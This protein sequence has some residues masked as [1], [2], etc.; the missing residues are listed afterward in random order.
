MKKNETLTSAISL[1]WQ[2][3]DFRSVRNAGSG[4]SKT[5]IYTTD[6]S[7]T[8]E[9]L[10]LEMEKDV[11]TSDI[12]PKLNALSQS[13]EFFREMPTM[14]QYSNNYKNRLHEYFEFTN[15]LGSQEDFLRQD[16]N[17]IVNSGHILSIEISTIKHHYS[18]YGD[19]LSHQ[20]IGD[21][22]RE[23]EKIKEHINFLLFKIT[24]SQYPESDDDDI[25]TVT[26]ASQLRYLHCLGFFEF[27]NAKHPNGK[28]AP[29]I[30]RIINTVKTIDPQLSVIRSNK[31]SDSNHPEASENEL[32]KAI[33]FLKKNNF[34]VD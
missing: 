3:Y 34:N 4:I 12:F 33:E 30:K 28:W 7:N 25:S 10:E 15:N 32:K 27:L 11:I 9:P 22:E 5:D 21:F 20:L 18:V 31:T 6:N 19:F 26:I 1:M 13:T 16:F 2:Y 8:G 14:K 17:E 23:I 24:G 29:V